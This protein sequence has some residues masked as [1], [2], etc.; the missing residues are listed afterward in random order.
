[1]SRS[2]CGISFDRFA[3]RAGSP[4]IFSRWVEYREKNERYAVQ[5]GVE[6][7]ERSVL[8]HV[9]CGEILLRGSGVQGPFRRRHLITGF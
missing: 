4:S 2:T 6:Y 8:P 1:M 5:T 3:G 9:E 7:E